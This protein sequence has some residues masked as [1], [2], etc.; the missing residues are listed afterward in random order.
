MPTITNKV[1][2]CG[3][4]VYGEMNDGISHPERSSDGTEGVVSAE[5]G[6]ISNIIKRKRRVT[7]KQLTIKT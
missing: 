1:N 3:C 7:I 4:Y 2:C 5:K 6:I